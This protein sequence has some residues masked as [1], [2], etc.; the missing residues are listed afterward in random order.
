[1]GKKWNWR[2]AARR[3]PGAGTFCH[4]VSYTIVS[5]VRGDESESEEAR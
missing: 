3:V 1:M 4:N 2:N 5:H